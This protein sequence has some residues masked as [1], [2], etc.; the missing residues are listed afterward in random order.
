[1]SSVASY[2]NYYANGTNLIHNVCTNMATSG[3]GANINVGPQPSYLQTSV[4][5]YSYDGHYFYTDYDQMISD[6]V[7][8]TRSN[9]VN[10]ENPYYNYYPY[11]PLRSTTVYSSNQLTNMI[12]AKLSSSSSKMYNTG[13]TFV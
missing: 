7:R 11:L 9:A 4:T 2:S 13:S 12:H 10:A 5:Y 8:N 6:Y 1:M 3:Y